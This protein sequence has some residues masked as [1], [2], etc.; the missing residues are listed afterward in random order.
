LGRGIYFLVVSGF[1]LVVESG[2]GLGWG[3]GEIAGAK[4]EVVEP[5][6]AGPCWGIE[7]V[8]V[9]ELSSKAPWGATIVVCRME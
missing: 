1:G 8:V 7:L 4:G 9:L 2:R 5:K 3:V 6:G